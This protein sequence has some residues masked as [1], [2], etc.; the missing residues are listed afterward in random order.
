MTSTHLVLRHVTQWAG[1]PVDKY[2]GEI[3]QILVTESRYRRFYGCN[4]IEHA[5]DPRF[6]ALDL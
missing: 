6:V 5:F 3:E 2:V 1:V 4:A